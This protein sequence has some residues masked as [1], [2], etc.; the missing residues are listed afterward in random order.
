MANILLT[1]A[2]GFVGRHLLKG[3]VEQGHD[4]TVPVRHLPDKENIFSA[5]GV[6]RVSGNFY[7]VAVLEHCRTFQ[8][9][10]VIHSAAIRGEGNGSP[11]DYQRVN[12]DGTRQLVDFA[13]RNTVRFFIYLS[14][15]G[16]YGTI[17]GELPARLTTPVAPDGHYHRSKWEGERI[18]SGMLEGKISY[19]ILRPSIIYGK[20]DDGFL[21]RLI[22]LVRKRMFPLCRRTILI[23]LVN[24]ELLV[25]L[26]TR[27][28]QEP[29]VHSGTWI[30]AD[31]SPVQLERVVHLIHQHYYGT[32]Y[33]GWARIPATFF[34][35]GEVL[36]RIFRLKNFEISLKLISRSWYYD[37]EPLEALG[38]VTLPDTLEGVQRLLKELEQ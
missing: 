6:H 10:I 1:G 12:V 23:H 20:G 31:R 17:P 25:R 14:S 34:R 32:P 33:P 3:L 8:P 7:D 29:P 13:L 19:L 35:F 15:V 21:P 24:I 28:V 27:F 26:I 38:L 9:E 2:T 36:F 16:V 18:V 4:V 37:V 22:A 11:E 5:P 30:V